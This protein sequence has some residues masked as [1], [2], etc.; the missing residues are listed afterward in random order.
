[1]VHAQS[2]APCW[3]I[4]RKTTVEPLS[5]FYMINSEHYVS[6]KYSD[7]IIGGNEELTQVYMCVGTYCVHCLYFDVI[8]HLQHHPWLLV[9]LDNIC[10][11]FVFVTNVNYRFHDT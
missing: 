3:Y 8:M 7:G 9:H 2:I 11:N 5:V 10:D 6:S 4:M 1:M